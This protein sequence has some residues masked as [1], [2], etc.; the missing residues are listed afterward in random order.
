MRKN[1]IATTYSSGSECGAQSVVVSYWGLL[2]NARLLMCAFGISDHQQ[3]ITDTLHSY[4]QGVWIYSFKVIMHIH[5]HKHVNMS[6]LANSYFLSVVPGRSRKYKKA[7]YQNN[8]KRSSTQFNTRDI[9][10]IISEV[11]H[12]RTQQQSA[13]VEAGDDSQLLDDHWLYHLSP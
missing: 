12:P 5:E 4:R 6:E 8:D 3:P 2:T 10:T 1:G 13:P 11:S 7:V 9:R